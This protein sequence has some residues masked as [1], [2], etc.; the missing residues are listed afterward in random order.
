M[1]FSS[2]DSSEDGLSSLGSQEEQDLM[3][4]LNPP[5]KK[6]VPP[7][8][9]AS[10]VPRYT[11]SDPGSD[12]SSSRSSSSHD[13]EASLDGFVTDD[14]RGQFE[15]DDEEDEKSAVH[16]ND[17]LQDSWEFDLGALQQRSQHSAALLSG[18]EGD[19]DALTFV[20]QEEEEAKEKT[21]KEAPKSQPRLQPKLDPEQQALLDQRKAERA[22]RMEQV[23]ARIAK[24]KAQK[25]Q[26]ER[27]KQDQTTKNP[28][29]IEDDFSDMSDAARRLRI[30]KWYTRCGMKPKVEMQRRAQNLNFGPHVSPEDVELLPWNFNG[31]LVNATQM[32]KYTEQAA[33]EKKQQQK[34]QT[35][36][37]ANDSSGSNS[38]DS[39]DSDA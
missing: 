15:G 7:P 32:L 28:I 20:S 35:T 19:D 11:T 34:Q 18:T 23:R 2:S 26:K 21:A 6:S 22:K 13:K 12:S 16:K 38:S 39:E 9:I 30:Y 4:Q 17:D 31:T 1:P 29:N 5:K 36:K 3:K 37:A 10:A 8:K 24:E 33:A 14:A 27:Q 25:Q